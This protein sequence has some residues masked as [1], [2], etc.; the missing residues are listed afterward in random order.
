VDSHW[1]KQPLNSCLYRHGVLYRT[2]CSPVFYTAASTAV[3]TQGHRYAWARSDRIEDARG[4]ADRMSQ[5]ES[6]DEKPDR[7]LLATSCYPR[8]RARQEE[9]RGTEINRAAGGLFRVSFPGLAL[10]RDEWMHPAVS[11]CECTCLHG[12]DRPFPFNLFRSMRRWHWSP[13]HVAGGE[14]LSRHLIMRQR[15]SWILVVVL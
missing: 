1:T 8:P 3:T 14:V 12:L 9:G 15:E 6:F 13:A 11:L 2:R 5:I 7:S 10:R 4:S